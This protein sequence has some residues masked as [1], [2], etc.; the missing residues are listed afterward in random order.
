MVEG[1]VLKGAHAFQ[2]YVALGKLFEKR[3]R[4]YMLQ[5]PEQIIVLQSKTGY[6]FHA[7]YKS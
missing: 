4:P 3:E 1:I 6:R 7:N 2:A 5:D